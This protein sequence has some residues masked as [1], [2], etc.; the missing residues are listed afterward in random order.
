MRFV[1]K[2]QKCSSNKIINNLNKQTIFNYYNLNYLKYYYFVLL[3][4]IFIINTTN[5][6]IQLNELK[7]LPKNEL[8]LSTLKKLLYKPLLKIDQMPFN[9]NELKNYKT[10]LLILNKN[11]LNNNK[12]NIYNDNNSYIEIKKQIK[13][14][15]PIKT[16]MHYFN[17]LPL[18]QQKFK[19]S[20]RN[21]IINSSHSN[22]NK[23]YQIENIKDIGW[24]RFGRK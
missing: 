15:V 13:K 14:I 21:N 6:F 2:Q 5:A 20:I 17:I 19:R 16:N 23:I 22:N 8:Y 1:I 10:K 3:Y 4:L 12:L 18:L 9:Q 7:F 11:L 24:F